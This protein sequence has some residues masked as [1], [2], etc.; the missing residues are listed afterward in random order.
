MLT[1]SS[2]NKIYKRR[3]GSW[4]LNKETVRALIDVNFSVEESVTVL[5]A[6]SSGSGKSTLARC[7]SGH[8]FP[9]TGQIELDGEPV[10]GS[11]QRRRSVQLVFQDAAMSFRPRMNVE[12]IVTEALQIDGSPR[13][14]LRPRCEELLDQVHL[15]ASVMSRSPSELSGGERNRVSI[16][17]SLAVDPRVLILDEVTSGLDLITRYSLLEL[18]R[19][20]QKARGLTVVLISHDMRLAATFADR[21]AVMDLGRI[22]EHRSATDVLR[23]PKQPCTRALLESVEP[24][25][26]LAT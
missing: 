26:R 9:D 16:A 19:T 14:R 22:V 21:I 17:R 6:G 4:R 5:V 25:P 20:I 23:E 7:L 11:R 13:H 8:E 10:G 3:S 1:A 2:V 15:P 18:L 12:A 24:L